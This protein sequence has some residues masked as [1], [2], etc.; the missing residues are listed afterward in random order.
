MGDLNNNG[1]ADAADVTLLSSYLVR[2]QTQVPTPPTSLTLI[3]T[4]ADPTLS[5][6]KS[7]QAAPGD[8]ITV[9]INIDTARPTGSYGMIGA[10]IAIRFD[11]NV[12]T[13]SAHEIQLG[14]LPARES[15]WQLRAEVNNVTGEIGIDLSNRLPLGSTDGGS[16]VTVAFQCAKPPARTTGASTLLLR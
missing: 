3:P 12:F 11:P 14:S 5:L 6:P 13:V 15:G 4:G 9:P 2:S 16:L 1:Q 7:L 8:V 10:T